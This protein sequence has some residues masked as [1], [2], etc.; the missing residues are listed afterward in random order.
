MSDSTNC[1]KSEVK[2]SIGNIE[3]LIGTFAMLWDKIFY[4]IEH[5]WTNSNSQYY[6]LWQFSV[7][8]W[9]LGWLLSSAKSLFQN[10]FSCILLK[11][12]YTQ[13]QCGGM[14]HV[15]T[16]IMFILMTTFFSHHI[17]PL[18]TFPIAPKLYKANSY[19]ATTVGLLLTV[20]CGTYCLWQFIDTQY[21]HSEHRAFG[22]IW[23]EPASKNH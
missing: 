12:Q 19:C 21:W 14:V 4:N 17:S 5:H 15:C 18:Q 23:K 16:F 13:I 22:F 1:L 8:L 6:M 10:L 9:I 7:Y 2:I 11:V 20:K 3:D